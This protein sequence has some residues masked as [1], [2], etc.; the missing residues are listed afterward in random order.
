MSKLGVRGAF[1]FCAPLLPVFGFSERFPP[2]NANTTS[3]LAEAPPFEPED[4]FL[5][6]LGSC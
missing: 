2:F 3:V 6:M 5:D 4:L 1:A